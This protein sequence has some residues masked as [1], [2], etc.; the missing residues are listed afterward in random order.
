MTPITRKN[1]CPHCGRTIPNGARICWRCGKKVPCKPITVSEVIFLIFLLLIGCCLS[2]YSSLGV[3]VKHD[4]NTII[5]DDSDITIYASDVYYG[6]DQL[7]IKILAENKTNENIGFYCSSFIV[8][9]VMIDSILWMDIAE[10]AKA[11]RTL[12]FD[13]TV[14]QNAGY[15][16]I[17][18]IEFYKPHISFTESNRNTKY[19]SVDC[20]FTDGTSHVFDKSGEVLYSKNGVTVISR[21]SAGTNSKKIPLMIINESGQDITPWTSHVTVNGYTVSEWHY[22]S[23]IKNNTSRYF[24]IQLVNEALKE[25]DIS[26]IQEASFNL[27]FLAAGSTK[28]LFSAGR[29]HVQ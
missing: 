9:N 22:G 15:E 26:S 28:E 7:S 21:F 1:F 23:V 6:T 19:I 17:S 3:S 5:Y 10:G 25:A 2:L 16:Q 18:Y 11:T 27:S 29:L 24:D 4:P 14:L 20:N 8:D 13:N 12:Y